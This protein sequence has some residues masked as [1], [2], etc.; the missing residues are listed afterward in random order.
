MKETRKRKKADEDLFGGEKGEWYILTHSEKQKKKQK[1]WQKRKRWMIKQQK[2][3]RRKN[4]DKL[5][6]GNVKMKIDG[7]LYTCK[8]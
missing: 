2:R 7:K 8:T 3:K 1:E 5:N 6:K 4:D